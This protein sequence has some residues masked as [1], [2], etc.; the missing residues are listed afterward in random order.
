MIIVL[1]SVLGTFY[2][3]FIILKLMF[4]IYL[5]SGHGLRSLKCL[6]FLEM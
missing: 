5:N 6:Y 1:V 2:E 3:Y 4:L